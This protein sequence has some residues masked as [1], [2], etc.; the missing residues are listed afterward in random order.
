VK[1]KISTLA[2][3]G[4][5][6]SITLNTP[7]IVKANPVVQFRGTISSM[8]EYPMNIDGEIFWIMTLIAD[9]ETKSGDSYTLTY[10]DMQPLARTES[11]WKQFISKPVES[12]WDFGDENHFFT[13]TGMYMVSQ[14]AVF[15]KGLG[16]H[17]PTPIR[18]KMVFSINEG[19]WGDSTIIQ[20]QTELMYLLNWGDF[21][22]HD[23]TPEDPFPV[24]GTIKGSFQLDN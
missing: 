13:A 24:T 21:I 18:A 12:E 11:G 20:G 23:G 15:P 10:T 4:I 16:E 1:N 7:I 9:V 17:T 3:V 8:H 5:I 22:E 14:F 6:L 2:I 19:T